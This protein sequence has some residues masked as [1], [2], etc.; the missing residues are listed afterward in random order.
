M[1]LSFPTYV[2]Y[3][4]SKYHYRFCTQLA[5]APLAQVATAHKV[6]CSV[7]ATSTSAS[8]ANRAV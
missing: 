7:A 4:C 1:H 5:A 6:S 3:S 2:S 8:F